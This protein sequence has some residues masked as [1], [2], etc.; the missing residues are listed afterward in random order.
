HVR[1]YRI[2]W[3]SIQRQHTSQRSSTFKTKKNIYN[4][5]AYKQPERTSKRKQ[6]I[7]ISDAFKS[8]QAIAGRAIP[9]Q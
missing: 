8:P 7:N 5:R 2:F 3:T 4:P 6:P 9:K 1:V